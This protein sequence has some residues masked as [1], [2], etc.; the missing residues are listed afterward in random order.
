MITTMIAHGA[1]LEDKTTTGYTALLQAAFAG[2]VEACRALLDNGADV[3]AVDEKGR[4]ARMLAAGKGDDVVALLAI[5][6]DDKERQLPDALI[7]TAAV[8]H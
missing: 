3:F 2:K 6:E 8:T 7:P 4:T 5:A 1:H